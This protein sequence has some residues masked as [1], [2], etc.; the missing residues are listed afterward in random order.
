MG[1]SKIHN[2]RKLTCFYALIIGTVLLL[3]LPFYTNQLIPN[4]FKSV[5][6]WFYKFEFNASFYYVFREIGYAF[7]GYNEIAIIGKITALLTITYLLY[8]AFFKKAIKDIPLYTSLLFG[9]SFYYFTTATIHPWYIAT[10]LILGV[11]SSYKFPVIW[12]FLLFLTYQTYTHTTWKENLWFVALEY[13]LLF[14]FLI[15]EIHNKWKLQ[16]K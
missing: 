12:S 2:I 7:R 4:Y 13:L 10:P 1:D 6:L 16:K 5:G 9:I 14:S 3:F 15:Y 11:F 8:L